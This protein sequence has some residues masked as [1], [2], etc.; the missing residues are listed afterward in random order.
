MDS[1]A[2]YVTERSF[3][4]FAVCTRKSRNRHTTTTDIAVV[5]S[6]RATHVNC[7]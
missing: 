5:P 3:V 6:S 4:V 1:N 7:E 2:S